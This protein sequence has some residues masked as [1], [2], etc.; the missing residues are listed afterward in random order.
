MENKE[1]DHF[2]SEENYSIRIKT[3]KKESICHLSLDSRSS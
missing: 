2:D 1:Y 3:K